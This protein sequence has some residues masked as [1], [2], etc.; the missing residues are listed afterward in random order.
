MEKKN[1]ILLVIVA[2]LFLEL[3]SASYCPAG[4]I[5]TCQ[6]DD[7]QLE[8]HTSIESLNEARDDP[9]S[10]CYYK[11]VASTVISKS[12]EP[13][14]FQV[15]STK[16]IA[17]EKIVEEI[18]VPIEQ[19]VEAERVVTTSKYPYPE[20]E[21]SFDFSICSSFPFATINPIVNHLNIFVDF[22]KLFC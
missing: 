18:E 4:K 17:K 7:G 15:I 3:S 6:C 12:N 1:I 21:P 2:S 16:T 10:C 20:L 8:K 22:E 13:K 5:F 11:P 14:D 19:E 9:N